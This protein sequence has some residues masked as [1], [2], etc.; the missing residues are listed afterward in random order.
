VGLFL[1]LKLLNH[2]LGSEALSRIGTDALRHVLLLPSPAI[3]KPGTSET[4]SVSWYKAIRP[5]LTG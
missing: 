2:A 3:D 4:L 5:V 1:K